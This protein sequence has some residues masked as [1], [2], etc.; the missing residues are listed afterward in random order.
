[1]VG[2]GTGATR[3]EVERTG[4]FAGLVTRRSADTRSLPPEQARELTRLVGELD[5]A[6]G[7]G[8]AQPG[9]SVPDGFSYDVLIV[10]GD[11][12][13]RLQARDPDVPAPLRPLLRFVLQQPQGQGPP[14]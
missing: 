9:R 4:G 10:A 11:A 5:L 6:A 8:D 1:M 13:R 14:R 12:Q 3:V 7:Q 2:G